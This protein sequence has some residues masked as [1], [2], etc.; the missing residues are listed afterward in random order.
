[1][2]TG[3]SVGAASDAAGRVASPGAAPSA[4]VSADLLS[5]CVPSLLRLPAPPGGSANSS[6]GP[7]LV[8][9]VC[10]HPDL[11]IGYRG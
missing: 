1:M 5:V 6:L 8:M 11:L 2:T 7:W 10:I 3:Q 9:I 4:A